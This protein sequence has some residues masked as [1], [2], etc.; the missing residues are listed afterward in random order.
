MKIKKQA[1]K[2]VYNSDASMI[3][4]NALNVIFPKSVQEIIDLVKTKT[5]L[6]PRGG[7]TG[8]AGGAVPL[9]ST[10]IDLSKMDK[11]LEIDSENK[12][13]DVEPGVILENLNL[14]LSYHNLEF[15]INPSSGKS[16]TI[17]GMIACNAVG[18]YA[19]KYGKTSDWIKDLEIISGKGE[20]ITLGKLNLSDVAGLEGITGIIIRAKLKLI[21]KKQRS[22]DLLK[23]REI[24]KLP[25]IIRRLKLDDD[26]CSIEMIDKITA[27]LLGLDPEHHLIV[28]YESDRGKFNGKKYQGIVKMRDNIYPMLAS[29]GYT[30]IEDPRVLVFKL[31]ELIQFLEMKRIPFFGHVA[32]GVLHPCFKEKGFAQV[33]DLL[34]L[35]K[36]LQGNVSG[37]HGI[38]LAKKRFVENNDKKIILNAKKRFDPEFKINPGKVIDKENNEQNNLEDNSGTKLTEQLIE[39]N[40]VQENFEEKIK[41][42]EKQEEKDFDNIIEEIKS[43]TQDEQK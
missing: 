37:E 3:P 5:N 11:I 33:E 12:T 27:D 18:K 38:G 21:E 2:L 29:E 20:K 24:E 10:I 1:E 23:V 35:V 42:Q 6:V 39:E 16:C 32:E 9:D 7:G 8:L 19:V 43:S 17:G 40:K 15:P 22:A 26:L 41:D 25:E 31:L 30:H 4:G 28:E 14:E 13:V 34:S 36:K